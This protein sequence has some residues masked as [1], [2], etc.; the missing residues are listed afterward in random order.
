MVHSFLLVFVL[1]FN[2]NNN[3]IDDSDKTKTLDHTFKDEEI[4]NHIRQHAVALKMEKD[5][6]NASLFS[7]L[8]KPILH[9]I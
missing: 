8:C 3:L 4:A 7:Q 1:L 9:E 6:E 2:N 5:S